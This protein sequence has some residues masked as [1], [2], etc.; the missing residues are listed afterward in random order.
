MKRGFYADASNKYVDSDVEF[1]DI[2]TEHHPA[3]TLVA[4]MS[5]LRVKAKNV[6]PDSNN[7]GQQFYAA[8]SND[9]E[10]V[11]VCSVITSARPE[12]PPVVQ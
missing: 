4:K 8:N 10:K 7:L 2:K 5:P 9:Q 1:D 6:K 12:Q 11:V 3:Q